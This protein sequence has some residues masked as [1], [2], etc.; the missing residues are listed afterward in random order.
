M[1][2]E[3]ARGAVGVPIY[4]KGAQVGLRSGL[5]EGHSLVRLYLHG[6]G[7][8]FGL[9]VPVKGCCNSTAYKSILYFYFRLFPTL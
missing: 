3:E 6:A 2:G 4:P 9:L 5:S 7:F 8:G 1:L